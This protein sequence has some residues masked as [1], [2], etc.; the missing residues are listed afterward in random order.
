ME[1]KT[2]QALDKCKSTIKNG[3]KEGSVNIYPKINIGTRLKRLKCNDTNVYKG[4]KKPEKR[5]R[6]P[7]LLAL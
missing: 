1:K 6:N 3:Q 2:K 5:V 7:I 4:R